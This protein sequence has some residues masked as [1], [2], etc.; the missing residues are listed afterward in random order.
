MGFFLKDK[1]VYEWQ[2]GVGL[3]Q[4][5]LGK[6]YPALN[7]WDK[8]W[9]EVLTVPTVDTDNALRWILTLKSIFHLIKSTI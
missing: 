4:N 1:A 7:E 2:L 9:Q 6:K 8:T 3:M 5:I